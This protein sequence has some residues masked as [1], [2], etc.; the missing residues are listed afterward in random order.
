MATFI[1]IL[2]LLTVLFFLVMFLRGNRLVWG[3]GLL[4]VTSAILLDTF[5]GTFGRQQLLDELGLSFYVLAGALFAGAAAWLWGLLRP[6]VSQTNPNAQRSASLATAPSMGQIW[7]DPGG[8]NAGT[9]F[10][11]Q[12]MFDQIRHGFSPEDVRDLIFDLGLNEND[13]IALSQETNDLI[14]KLIDLAEKQGQ[15]GALALA[16][17]RI[18]TPV[19]PEHLPRPEKLSDETP[20]PVLRHYLLTHYTLSEMAGLAEALD[21]DWELIAGESK[22]AKARNL[23]LHLQRRHRLAELIAAM[24]RTAGSPAEKRSIP[25]KPGE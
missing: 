23:L 13:V 2:K 21:V 12:M 4:T 1:L 3:I 19:R 11:R 6:T 10:D 15:T 18:M 9:L 5:L 17:E 22:P 20:G 24:R 7:A 25:R 16:V 8:D 14:V